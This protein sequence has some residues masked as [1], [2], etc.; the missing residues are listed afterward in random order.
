MDSKTKFLNLSSNAYASGI[1]F[2]VKFYK[3]NLK[4]Q[5]GGNVHL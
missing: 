4:L 1:C 2:Y 5:F 3:M